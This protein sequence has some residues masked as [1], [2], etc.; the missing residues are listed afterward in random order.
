MNRRKDGYKVV[1]PGFGLTP[2]FRLL[3]HLVNAKETE[4]H[5]LFKDMIRDHSQGVALDEWKLKMLGKIMDGMK[6]QPRAS[7]PDLR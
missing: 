6:P 7:T 4:D 1:D 3:E 5:E 2:E